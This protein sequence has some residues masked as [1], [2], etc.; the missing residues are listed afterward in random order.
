MI[1]CNDVAVQ[2]NILSKTYSALNALVIKY[3]ALIGF[4]QAQIVM[5]NEYQVYSG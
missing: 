5:N 1:K 4:T 2:E 3:V